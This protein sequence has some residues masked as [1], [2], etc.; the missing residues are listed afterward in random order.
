MSQNLARA[1]AFL[2]VKFYLYS[3]IFAF[4]LFGLITAYLQWLQ[5]PNLLN[6]AVADVAILLIALSMAMSG[7]AYF[8]N[9]ADRQVIYRKYIGVVG[10]VFALWH[11]LLSWSAFLNLFKAQT[12]ASGRMWPMLT[13]FIALVIFAIMALISNQLSTKLLGTNLWRGILRFGYVGLLL[14]MV[15][16]FL[17]KSARW[18]TWWQEGMQSPP[19]L[20]LVVV[21][22]G[23]MTVLLRLGLWWSLKVR[24][25]R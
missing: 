5:I 12:W 11:L 17:L 23:A 9:F 3:T 2:E 6:K 21:M 8:F 16:V 15:H 7:L 4:I 13:G 24:R 1:K 10:F 20:S 14:V 22:V 25:N 19:A 18:L